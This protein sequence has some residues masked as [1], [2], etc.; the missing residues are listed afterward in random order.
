MKP[1][2]TGVLRVGVVPFLNTRPLVRYIDTTQPP[3]LNL[4]P[5]VPSRLA[6]MMQQSLLDVAVLPSIEYLRGT[7]YRIIPDISISADGTVQSVCIFSKKPIEE[8]RSLALDKSS[9][10]SA[11]LA[12]ILLKRRL[13]SLPQLTTCSPDTHMSNL[14][15]DAMLL[16]GDAAMT[17]SPEEPAFVLD[18]GEEWKKL[19]GLPFVYAMWVKRNDVEGN[20]LHEKLLQARDEGLTRLREIAVEASEDL[21]LSV[22]V[23][24]GYLRDIM[25]Y[26]LGEREL[27][28][29]RLFQSLAAEDGLCPGGVE[30]AVDRR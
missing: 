6:E 1:E 19:T 22:E 26:E 15:A 17:I 5:E 16:I 28:S 3:P 14:D 20:R 30:I 29:L 8:I 7:N 13:G 27:E 21:G 18:L 23:C 24:H 25:R 2:T 4:V 9:R 11:A 10:T 12:R